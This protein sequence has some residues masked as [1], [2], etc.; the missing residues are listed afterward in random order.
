MP[1]LQRAKIKVCHCKQ[2]D[3][4]PLVKNDLAITPKR[5][6]ELTLQ[7]KPISEQSASYQNDFIEGYRGDNLEFEPPHIYCRHADMISCFN[8]QI[9]SREQAKVMLDKFGKEDVS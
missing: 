8:Q 2:T 6:Y 5:M 3:A 7:G 9:E 1:L 4:D